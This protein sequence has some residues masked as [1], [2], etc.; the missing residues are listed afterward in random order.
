MNLDSLASEK[1]RVHTVERLE[2]AANVEDRGRVKEEEE[3]KRA[4]AEG[5]DKDA[6]ADQNGGRF[7][8]WT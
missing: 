2:P 7:E 1:Q 4:D 5:N 8:R 6:E 3:N